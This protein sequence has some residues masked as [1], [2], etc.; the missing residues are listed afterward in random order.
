MP[1]MVTC[2]PAVNGFAATRLAVPAAHEA[3]V[4]FTVVPWSATAMS[5]PLVVLS[6]FPRATLTGWRPPTRIKI[7]W[8]VG[9]QAMRVQTGRQEHFHAAA[10]LVG[11]DDI[12]QAVAVEIGLTTASGVKPCV[13]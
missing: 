8:S 1:V 2:S 4:M 3:A 6:K 12:G 7:A 11:N 9:D 13:K 5:N 10:L